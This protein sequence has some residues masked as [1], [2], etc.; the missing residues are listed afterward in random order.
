MKIVYTAHI[1][2]S[3]SI[4]DI[5]GLFIAL[6][7]T[8]EEIMLVKDNG[9]DVAK[10]YLTDFT[11][12]CIQVESEYDPTLG[13]AW[14]T[15][16]NFFSNRA[17]SSIKNMLLILFS[18]ISDS[19]T[20]ASFLLEYTHVLFSY[21]D[22]IFLVNHR[23]EFWNEDRINMLAGFNYKFRDDFLYKRGEES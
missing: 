8:N 20:Q 23:N 15:E 14:N 12:T 19:A 2:T 17:D 9:V 18:L 11:I 5:L 7:E 6:Q 3:K 13:I 22:T 4:I 21:A 1:E 10:L 16:I